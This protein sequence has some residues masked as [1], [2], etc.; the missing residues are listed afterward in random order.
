ML[1]TK[2]KI[3]HL[4]DLPFDAQLVERELKKANIQYEKI[5]VDN[6][7][8]YISSL[9]DFSPDIILSDH[10]LPSFNSIEALKIIKDA[11]LN[12]PFILI[13]ST[14][15]EEHVVDMMQL[16]ISDYIF[17]DRLKRLPN[18]IENAMEKKATEETKQKFIEQIIVNETLLN[19]VQQLARLGSLD[20]DRKRNIIKWSDELYKILGYKIGEVEPSL[21]NLLNCV[22]PEDVNQVRESTEYA[23][24][25]LDS[26]RRQFRLKMKDG[27]IKYIDSVLNIERDESKNVVRIKGFNQDIT[28]RV[29]LEKKLVDE[30]IKNQKEI[31]NAVIM[32][33]EKERSLLGEELHDNI[34]QVLATSKLYLETAIAD[35]GL[36]K[37]LLISS[38]E[39]LL[40]AMEEI[41][42]LSKSLLPPSLGG[43]NLLETLN[44]L[45]EN[46]QRVS[47]LH[48][49]K[50]WDYFDESLLDEKLS[51]A[52]YRIVQEQVN[53]ILKHAKATTVI[54]RLK[55]NAGTLQLSIKDDGVGFDTAEKKVGVGL[56][57]IVSRIELFK[58]THVINSKPEQGCE[59]IVSFNI[60][61]KAQ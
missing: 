12:I 42:K 57:N 31:T 19:E 10:S 21:E 50:E 44:E 1:S 37:D 40:N 34:N 28:E 9:K 8:S 2:L 5:V 3:L 11:G 48:F 33:Q 39:F 30:K 22:H 51:L 27:D 36:R 54:I 29:L 58:G 38:R 17:K 52:I 55:Q 25:H 53:N 14:I 15:S 24:N 16:G 56:K 7:A 4:E 18:A 41:R 60:E 45:I 13:T 47:T 59:L 49:I 23:I 43:T 26:F 6:R 61:S 32:A 35:D 46:I 20:V